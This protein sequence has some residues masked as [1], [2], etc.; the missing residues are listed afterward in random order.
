V[1]SYFAINNYF[2]CI[3]LLLAV[4]LLCASSVNPD[5]GARL[6]AAIARGGIVAIPC[7][8]TFSTQIII[9][10]PI[11]LRGSG[12]GSTAPIQK[13]GTEQNCNLH[14]N[15]SGD[16][17]VIRLPAS[18][19]L[20]GVT[21]ED[22][23]LTGNPQA[24]SGSG[25]VLNGGDVSTQMANIFLN[26]ITVKDFGDDGI[27]ILDNVFLVKAWGVSTITNQG[28][29]WEIAQTT[30]KGVPSQIRCF[31]CLSLQNRNDGFRISRG[32][33]GSIE[34]HGVTSANNGGDG[35]HSVG[36][37][38]V[39]GGSFEAN[40]RNGLYTESAESVIVGTTVPTNGGAGIVVPKGSFVQGVAHGGGSLSGDIIWR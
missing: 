13:A 14:W 22:F 31:D 27:K 11:I 34:F 39:F 12:Q 32:A 10:N 9:Q 3:E 19:V 28:N 1:K 4:C 20:T 33:S 35:I 6:T 36:T 7:G 23:T 25:L 24:K 5:T 8:A 40:V 15:G 37:I 18:H 16:A 38:Y 30:L 26:R 21:L 29:G 17:I 2:C